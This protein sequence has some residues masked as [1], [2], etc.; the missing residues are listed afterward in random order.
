MKY[1]QVKVLK[2][3]NVT[4]ENLDYFGEYSEGDMVAIDM[5]H[6]GALVQAGFIEVVGDYPSAS[7]PADIRGFK[8]E[9]KSEEGA[10]DTTNTAHAE[11]A[12]SDDTKVQEEVAPESAEA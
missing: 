9:V 12:A 7:A 1:K 10:E 5:D 4:D 3:W 2:D 11:L 6:T 8:K